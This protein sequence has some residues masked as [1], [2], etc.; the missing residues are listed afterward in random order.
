MERVI[1]I[2][3]KGGERRSGRDREDGRRRRRRGSQWCSPERE[4]RGSVT[5]AR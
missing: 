3:E 1:Y 5:H 2:P 4:S